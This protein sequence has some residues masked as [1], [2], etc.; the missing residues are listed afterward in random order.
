MAQDESMKAF[1]QIV[2]VFGMFAVLFG[3]GMVILASR[4]L[5]S[6]ENLGHPEKLIGQFTDL[7]AL[8]LLVGVL[9]I[10]LSGVLFG[11]SYFLGNGER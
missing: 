2:G 3:I 9:A 7:C 1:W 6:G 11:F 5:A 8:L 4:V 10:G